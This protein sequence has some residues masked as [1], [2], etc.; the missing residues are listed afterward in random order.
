MADPITI[1]GL[2]ADHGRLRAHGDALVAAVASLQPSD[3]ARLQD[4]R[5]ALTREA[6]Q[7]LILDERYVLVPLEGHPSPAVRQKTA[8]MRQDAGHFQA[9]CTSH[10]ADWSSDRVE[11]NWRSYGLAVRRLVSRMNGRLD[12]EERELYPLLCSGELAKFGHQ[13]YNWAGDALQLRDHI[14]PGRPLPASR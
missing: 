13:G 14:Y 12:R 10:I 5:W 6:H 8:E 2:V 1:A 3:A 9:Y 7:H 11:T 4:L